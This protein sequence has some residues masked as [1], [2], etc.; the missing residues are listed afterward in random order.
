MSVRGYVFSHDLQKR[1]SQKGNEY[2]RGILNVATDADGINIVPVNFT[3]VTPTFR[4]GN[5]NT[6]YQFLESVINGLVKTF[7][8][9]RTEATRVRIDGD[10][11]VN[12]WIT[13]DGE[14]ASPKRVRGSFVHEL[15]GDEEIGD[16]PVHFEADML[17]QSAAERETSDGSDFLELRGFVFNFRKDILPVTFS[18]TSQEGRDFFEA[19]DISSA[20]PFFGEVW[21]TIKTNTVVTQREADTSQVGF[22]TPKVQTSTRSFRSWEVAGAGLNLGMGEE[23]ISETELKAAAAKRENDL[24]EVRKHWNERQGNSANNVGFPS[25]TAPAAKPAATAASV[26]DFKF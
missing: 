2:I 12:D 26:A 15:R 23:T 9:V 19:Q 20:N 17:I 5:P 1:V 7:E 22:G 10:I 11:E 8:R 21:G 16:D 24:A 18:V 25:N 6:T 4:N 13:R 14:L 3:Y